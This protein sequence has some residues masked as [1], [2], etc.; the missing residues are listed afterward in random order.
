M[1]HTMPH[2]NPWHPMHKSV[3][4]D[5]FVCIKMAAADFP[6]HP[7]EV[8]FPALPTMRDTPHYHARW[9]VDAVRHQGRSHEDALAYAYNGE[10]PST[11]RIT[12]R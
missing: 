3:T 8:Y 1:M 6:D 10:V 5:G 12:P 4:D 7:A 11:L 9:Y 2:R